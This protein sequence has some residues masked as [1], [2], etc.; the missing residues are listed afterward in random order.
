MG[1]DYLEPQ[2]IED[3]KEIAQCL[4]CKTH[5]IPM[6]CDEMGRF[7]CSNKC[8]GEYLRRLN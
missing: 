5:F 6:F 7:Y 8:K 3:E 1:H 4:N 2:D